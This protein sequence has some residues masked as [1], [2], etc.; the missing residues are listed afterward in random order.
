MEQAKSNSPKLFVCTVIENKDEIEEVMC[1][2]SQF[3]NKESFSRPCTTIISPIGGGG[4]AKYVA[5]KFKF[6]QISTT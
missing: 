6:T 5:R 2:I 3:P 1:T 4:A